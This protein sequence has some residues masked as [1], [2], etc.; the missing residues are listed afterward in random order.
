MFDYPIALF[1]QDNREWHQLVRTWRRGKRL[2]EYF[3]FSR[4][5]IVMRLVIDRDVPRLLR[6]LELGAD[7]DQVNDMGCC[8]LCVAYP[9]E[10]VTEILLEHGARP[11][12]PNC[13]SLVIRSIQDDNP[14]LLG[15]YLFHGAITFDMERPPLHYAAALGRNTLVRMLLDAGANPDEKDLYGNSA[16]IYAGVHPDI[17]DLVEPRCADVIG[18]SDFT[19]AEVYTTALHSTIVVRN[20]CAARKLLQRGAD[21]NLKDSD[22]Y[23][24]LHV[25]LI[26]GLSV[27]FIKDILAAGADPNARTACGMLPLDLAIDYG[28]IPQSLSLIQYGGMA[29][30]ISCVNA[31]KADG[32][33]TVT[34]F[35]KLA[36]QNGASPSAQVLKQA[37]RCRFQK[38]VKYLED[39]L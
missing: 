37:K 26:K 29:S 11:D 18:R 6:A 35:M 1:D 28:M 19:G 32:D 17:F 33:T 24:P 25:A 2:G 9:H 20:V 22:K 5:L 21:V 14:R 12:T 13:D 34:A 30:N 16:L 23:T 4:S 8:A 36:V 39:R 3:E 7:T 27:A 10:D 15:M 38:C 31:L